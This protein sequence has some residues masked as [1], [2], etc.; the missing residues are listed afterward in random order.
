MR[1]LTGIYIR[2]WGL[3]PYCLL[4]SLWPAGGNHQSD[5]TSA[6]HRSERSRRGKNT[7]K[8]PSRYK[9]SWK[10]FHKEQNV[11][12]DLRDV[13]GI[14]FRNIVQLF[15][16]RHHEQL[17]ILQKS[18]KNVTVHH[19]RLGLGLQWQWWALIGRETEIFSVCCWR[20]QS[21]DIKNKLG[22]PKSPT[23]VT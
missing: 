19:R 3:I 16:T 7:T 6:L 14:K 20:Q 17:Q 23:L 2:T 15:E 12:T 21:C 8:I 22:H 13:I 4:T 10:P 18:F 5:L 9:L 1:S 11:T